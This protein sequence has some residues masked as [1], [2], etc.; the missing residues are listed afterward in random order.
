[1]SLTSRQSVV[2]FLVAAAIIIGCAG[3]QRVGVPRS[4]N[5]GEIGDRDMCM[6]LVWT[7]FAPCNRV[8]ILAN[9]ALIGASSND[10]GVCRVFFRGTGNMHFTFRLFQRGVLRF[11]PEF[12]WNAVGGT[13]LQ[14]QFVPGE[15]LPADEFG[16]EPV[17]WFPSLTEDFPSKI[18]CSFGWAYARTDMFAVTLLDATYVAGFKDRLAQGGYLIRREMGPGPLSF[19]IGP[20]HGSTVVQS[21]RE[22]E[23][24]DGVASVDPMEER[25]AH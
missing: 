6:L 1:M 8:E 18:W 25:S 5:A 9:G 21:I 13:M 24:W 16:P 17:P 10:K 3:P 11:Q 23:H 2:V 7:G 15:S 14:A 4:E 22:I 20:P 19:E 12:D